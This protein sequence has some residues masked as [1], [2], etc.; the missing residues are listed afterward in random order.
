MYYAHFRCT[1]IQYVS[2]VLKITIRLLV[3]TVKLT[4]SMKP[5]SRGGDRGTLLTQ[6]CEI[7][8]P[9]VGLRQFTNRT[10]VELHTQMMDN[11]KML[12]EESVTSE[13]V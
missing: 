8:V 2:P 1:F 10:V 6:R 13:D 3:P 11:Y 4:Y 9:R 12:L 5:T 7:Y